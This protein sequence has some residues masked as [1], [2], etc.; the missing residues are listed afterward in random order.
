MLLLTSGNFTSIH[1]NYSVPGTI[2]DFCEVDLSLLSA[3]LGDVTFTIEI[4]SGS[5]LR[6]SVLP[7][8]FYRV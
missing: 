8:E 2:E 1:V 5:A 4:F 7:P 6:T 3:C